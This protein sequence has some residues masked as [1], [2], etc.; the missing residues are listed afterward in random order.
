[1]HDSVPIFF[2]IMAYHVATYHS[3]IVLSIPLPLMIG[4]G[5]DNIVI[6][7]FIFHLYNE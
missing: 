1:M 4:G 6:L 2:F 5:I 3:H 7:F